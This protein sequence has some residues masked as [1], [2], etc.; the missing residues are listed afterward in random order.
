MKLWQLFLMVLL[1]STIG[2]TSIHSSGFD[3]VGWV[4][5]L[6]Q[7]IPKPESFWP[8]TVGGWI[9]FLGGTIS[10][11][12]I[13]FD[14]ITGRASNWKDVT[15]DIQEL[16]KRA[17]KV[18]AAD[19]EICKTLNDVDNRVKGLEFEVKGYDGRGG[20]RQIMDKVLDELH[21]I[22]ERN[23]KADILAGIFERMLENPGYGGPERRENFRSLRGLLGK[24]ENRDT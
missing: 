3:L 20:I 17:D 13:A 9:G 5:L 22:H 24:E 12:V 21:E 14:R 6:V 8:T 11:G 15:N 10:V 4:Y 23:K 2:P 16:C 7:D 19:K 18:E 1:L